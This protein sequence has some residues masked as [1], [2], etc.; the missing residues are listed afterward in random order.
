MKS[1]F[2]PDLNLRAENGHLLGVRGR[3]F[4]PASSWGSALKLKRSRGR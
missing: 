4:T 2:A 3:M 1:R